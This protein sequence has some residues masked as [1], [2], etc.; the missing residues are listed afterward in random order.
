MGA[1]KLDLEAMKAN[2]AQL[3]TSGI[4]FDAFKD[5]PLSA[6]GVR[7][8]R[9]MHDVEYHTVCYLRDLLVTK[10]HRD[11]ELTSFLTFWNFEEYWHGEAIGRVLAEHGEG[12]HD[13]RVEDLRKRLSLKESFKPL[14]HGM[15]SLIA[16]REW[17]AVHMSWGAV[18]E[19]TT[20]AGYG[21]LA[22]REKHPVLGELLKR[23]MRQEG[24]HIDFYAAHAMDALEG[25]SRA[26]KVVR[27]T[28]GKVWRPVGA[29]VMPRPEVDHMTRY[30]FG[31]ED[32]QVAAERVD[33][34]VDRLPGQSGLHLL[35]RT[36]RSLAA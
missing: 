7:C 15:S 34:Q 8:L 11:H 9:Y 16:G 29:S 19:W 35:R 6:D 2:T 4:D 31:D 10:A 20:Q 21:R 18:N 12:A 14:F 17:M 13:E 32:G 1:V 24:R 23:I 5:E 33:R 26:Q 36:V 30:L 25:S 28:L 3:D 22:A 27:F